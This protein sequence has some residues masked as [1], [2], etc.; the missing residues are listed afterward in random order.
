MTLSEFMENL[1]LDATA[2]VDPQTWN[3]IRTQ[4]EKA[5]M[6]VNLIRAYNAP[7]V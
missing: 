7:A 5:V 6:F 3:M 2:G 4:R 1:A